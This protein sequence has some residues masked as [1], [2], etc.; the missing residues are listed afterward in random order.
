[1]CCGNAS[2]VDTSS[3]ANNCGGCGV[4]CG[5]TC[6]AGK[7]L[8][9]LASAQANPY[10]IAVDATNVYWTNQGTAPGY[11][12]G[13]V[14]K[15]AIAGCGGTPTVLA[16]GQTNP[17]GIAVDATSVYWTNQGTAA[18]NYLDGTVAKCAIGGCAGNPTTLALGQGNPFGITVSATS[19]YWTN[20]GDGRVMSCAVGG[21]SAPTL[22]ATGQGPQGIVADATNLYWANFQS[23]VKCAIGLCTAST[24]LASA[25]P[26]GPGIAS[27]ASS[28]FFT[29]TGACNG[30]PPCGVESVA[31]TGGTAVAITP[32]SYLIAGNGGTLAVDAT[33]VY[34]TDLAVYTCPITGC[35]PS[36]LT[37]LVSGQPNA[38]GIAVD[39]TSVYF[40]NHVAGGTVAKLTPK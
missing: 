27:N 38:F 2:C 31:K 40:T 28:V 30:G 25:A 19:V 15:C 22:L 10:F 23:V 5:G 33:N 29:D 1:V 37:T 14:M 8:L 39:A 20:R 11:A 6:A 32:I 34:W 26:A 13:S 24:F 9:T 7:C 3:D 12:D 36:G 17:A 4:V 16:S 21:C 35:G 18:K